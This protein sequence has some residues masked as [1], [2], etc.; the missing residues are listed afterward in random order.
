MIFSKAEESMWDKPISGEEIRSSDSDINDKYRVG[1]QRIV[2]EINREKIP[3]FVEALKNP[4]Y[5]QVR[6]FYQ[7]RDRWDVERQS[8]LIESFI[9][10]IPV[11]PIFLYERDFNKYEVMDGQQRITALKSF[12]NGEYRLSG[13][14]VWKELNG[15]TYSTLPTL[16]RQGLDR[17]SISNIVVLKESTPDEEGATFLRQ[18]VFERL[19]TGGVKLERQ[20]IRNCI[21]Q[22]KFNDLLMKLTQLDEFRDAFGMPRYIA[23][24]D[25]KNQD[26]KG[27]TIYQKLGDVE[28]VLRFFAL[29]HVDKYTRGM[30][31]FLDLYMGRAMKFEDSDLKLLGDLFEKTFK[32]ATAVYG[33]LVFKPYDTVSGKWET[34]THK[35]FYDAVAVG[36]SRYIDQYDKIVSLKAEIIEKTKQL[37]IDNEPGVFTGRGNSKKD[38]TERIDKYSAMVASVIK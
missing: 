22:G 8:K 37:F 21:Y 14:E 34:L 2:T 30:Q 33:S 3:N 6:P 13:L 32:L 18:T 26:L 19:N 5:M 17:R 27:M 12:Y 1:E 20:E 25:D 11:P 31:G 28:M 9:M 7:R 35:A 16:I 10:N 23:G 36:L 15:R 38:V 24:Q 4:D 29:R